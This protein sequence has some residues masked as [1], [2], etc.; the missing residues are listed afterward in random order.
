MVRTGAYDV[1][2]LRPGSGLRCW[3]GRSCEALT[4]LGKGLVLVGAALTPWL[5]VLAVAALVVWVVVRR[6]R[7]PAPPVAP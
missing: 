7:R 2:T 6:A 3:I 4:N 5:P 1:P